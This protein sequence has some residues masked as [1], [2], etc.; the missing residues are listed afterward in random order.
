[1]FRH[2]RKADLIIPQLH[3][4]GLPYAIPEVLSHNRIENGAVC[5]PS[6][7]LQRFTTSIIDRVRLSKSQLLCSRYLG[8]V[9][10]GNGCR[11]W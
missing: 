7:G 1:M 11:D 4:L 9:V 2:C 3:S 8:Q 10:G 6:I 5:I